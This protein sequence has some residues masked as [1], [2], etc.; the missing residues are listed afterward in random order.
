VR[1]LDILKGTVS[2]ELLLASTSVCWSVLKCVEVCKGVLE[3]VGVCW[4]VLES[5]GVYC[6]VCEVI[7]LEEQ[8]GMGWLRFAGFLKSWVSF[9]EY[10]LF[11]RA[12]L[13]KRPMI[14]RS[15]LIEA[16]P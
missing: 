7:F 11:Y 9:A 2:N 14:L 12:V 16:S 15:F 3:C 8:Y 10:P 4:S 5:I 1:W 6:I 13:Q